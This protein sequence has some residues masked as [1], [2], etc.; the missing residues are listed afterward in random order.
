MMEKSN[1]AA[2]DLRGKNITREGCLNSRK[3]SVSNSQNLILST[4]NSIKK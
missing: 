3:K 1:E 2:R 4:N